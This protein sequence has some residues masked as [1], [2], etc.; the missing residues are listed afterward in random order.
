M[1]RRGPLRQHGPIVRPI[2]ASK[3]HTNGSHWLTTPPRRRERLLDGLFQRLDRPLLPDRLQIGRSAASTANDLAS[4][5]ITRLPRGRQERA[6]LAAA[7]VDAEDQ[8]ARS[9]G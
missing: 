5:V 6:R 2:G 9:E 7:P 4:H 1:V 3:P 8:I